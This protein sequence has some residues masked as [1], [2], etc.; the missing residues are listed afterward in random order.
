M[1]SVPIYVAARYIIEHK[2]KYQNI[3][4]MSENIAVCA[5]DPLDKPI[6]ADARIYQFEPRIRIAYFQFFNK[7]FAVTGRRIYYQ[8]ICPVFLQNFE[9]PLCYAVAKTYNFFI[10]FPF[11]FTF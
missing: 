2:A 6:A 7:L 3:R 9:A 5:R 10:H 11:P 8:F 1:F 4:V